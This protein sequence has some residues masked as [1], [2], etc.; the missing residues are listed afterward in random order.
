M[1]QEQRLKHAP[2]ATAFQFMPA[3][4]Q[5]PDQLEKKSLGSDN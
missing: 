4:R 5:F 2:N 1:I 3:M